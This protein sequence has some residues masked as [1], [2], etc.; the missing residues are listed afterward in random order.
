MS[1]DNNKTAF[2]VVDKFDRQMSSTALEKECSFWPTDDDTS[3]LFLIY[4]WE[5]FFI[6]RFRLLSRK[7]GIL[8]SQRGLFCWI[9]IFT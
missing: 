6:S 4:Y 7:P 8:L 1:S 3:L 5:I 9:F 2:L